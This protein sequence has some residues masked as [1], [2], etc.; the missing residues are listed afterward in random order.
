MSE[1]WKIN[2]LKSG[3]IEGWVS[4]YK[5][6]PLSPFA[7]CHEDEAEDITNMSAW[8][9]ELEEKLKRVEKASQ[10]LELSGNR[11]WGEGYKR[12]MS[13]IHQ[14]LA[15]EEATRKY[16]K[17]PVEIYAW[18]LSEVNRER[19]AAWCGGAWHPTRKP[20]YASALYI[21][22][23]EGRM[24]ADIGDFVVKGVKGEFYPCKPDI[25]NETYDDIA[26]E[27]AK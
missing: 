7:Y 16:R 12:A 20:G 26:G 23:L 27:E 6:H 8:V 25:F 13:D 1:E 18:Q 22:T 4:L 5:S 17:K 24:K 9:R 2:R 21:Q 10:N 14:A 3:G 15:G 11:E 19:V